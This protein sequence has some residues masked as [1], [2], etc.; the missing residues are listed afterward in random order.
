MSVRQHRIAQL[1]G[2]TL[3]IN[4]SLL[5]EREKSERLA[6]QLAQL[7][8]DRDE[9]ARLR[10]EVRDL[11]EQLARAQELSEQAEARCQELED[12]L[13]AAEEVAQAGEEAREEEKLQA[14][15]QEAAEAQA[16]ADELREQLE[17][18]QQETGVKPQSTKAA[19]RKLFAQRGGREKG[20]AEL[21]AHKPPGEI[22][23]LLM[24]MEL[25]G[26]DTDAHVAM[27]EIASTYSIRKVG[28]LLI[29]ADKLSRNLSRTILMGFGEARQPEDVLQLIRDF[30]SIAVGRGSNLANQVLTWFSWDRPVGDI[31]KMVELLRAMEWDELAT[32]CL[33]GAAMHQPPGQL[34]Q[35]INEATGDR[36]ALLEFTA[37]SRNVDRLVPLIVRMRNSDDETLS[38]LLAKLENNYPRKSADVRRMIEAVGPLAD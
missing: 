15:L 21:V 18:L 17:R 24:R 11:K 25:S 37:S 36:A 28:L 26:R 30:G 16:Q 7:L 32:H 10:E 14:A 1:E 31:T 33:N 35:L 29:E 34:V 19:R 3:Q 13:Q 4:S 38:E 2:E 20:F 27:R 23:A 9:L 22:A 6:H 8:P 12:Q 5:E